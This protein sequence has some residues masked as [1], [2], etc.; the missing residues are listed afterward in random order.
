MSLT[1]TWLKHDD[2]SFCYDGQ[3]LLD[4]SLDNSIRLAGNF[5]GG[6]YS[7]LI[8][9]LVGQS[10]VLYNYLSSMEIEKIAEDLTWIIRWD[11]EKVIEELPAGFTY[12]EALSIALM[13]KWYAMQED[14]KG[15]SGWY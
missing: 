1:N 13:F 6:Q 10:D 4:T 9:S 8:D 2:D 11:K 7:V 5:Y 14:L 12:E 15:L 3:P